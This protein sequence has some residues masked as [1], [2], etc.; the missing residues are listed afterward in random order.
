[1]GRLEILVDQ[2][3]PVQVAQRH[4]EPNGDAQPLR[5]RHRATQE[6]RERLAPRVGEHE[7]GPPLVR[8]ERQRPHR[9]GGIEFSS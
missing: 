1:M 8:D 2:A 9:P 7:H 4:R 6:T 5:Q 3:P